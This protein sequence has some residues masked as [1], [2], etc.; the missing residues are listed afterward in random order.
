MTIDTKKYSKY[1]VT[2]VTTDGRRFKPKIY[3]HP[4]WAFGINLWKGS[5]WG[6]NK[7]TRKWELLNR[8]P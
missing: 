2:G 7:K 1:K 5:V 8:V 4:H 3:S 6:W